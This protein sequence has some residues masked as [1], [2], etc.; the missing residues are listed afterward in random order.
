MAIKHRAGSRRRACGFTLIEL[1]IVV[2]IIGILAAIAL[3]AYNNYLVKSKLTEATSMLDASKAAIMDVYTTNNGVFPSALWPP[4]IV[5]SVASNAHYV[6]A[7]KYNVSGSSAG[8]ILTLG[9]TG[10]A[11]IDG[12][13]MGI[14]G[15]AQSDGTVSWTCATANNRNAS[16]YG[17]G[18]AVPTMYPFL[19]TACQN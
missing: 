15:V 2:A 8:V 7:V 16:A 5:Q 13:Y 9:N 11:Q 17:S 3:P 1:M 4:V 6:T 12:A 14:F 19:P 18:V 10:S